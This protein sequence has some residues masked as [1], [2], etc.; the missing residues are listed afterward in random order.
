M[1]KQVVLSMKDT[2]DNN[3]RS[4]IIYDFVA[5]GVRWRMVKCDRRLFLGTNSIDVVFDTVAKDRGN[6]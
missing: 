3:G 2:W 5:T 6:R 1:I 4:G